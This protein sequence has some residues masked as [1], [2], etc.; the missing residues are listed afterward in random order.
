[1]QTSGIVYV[2]G[3]PSTTTD[4]QLDGLCGRHGTVKAARVVLLFDN[5]T[6]QRQ[7]FGIVEMASSG[8]NH[9]VVAA[10]HRSTLDI[11]TLRCFVLSGS[12]G[13]QD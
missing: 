5:M 9:K 12:L 8:D 3:L 2:Q 11:S 7:G 4:K 6:R 1:M 13:R 10:L